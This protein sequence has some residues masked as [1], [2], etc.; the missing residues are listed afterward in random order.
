MGGYVAPLALSGHSRLAKGPKSPVL[1]SSASP[2]KTLGP[3]LGVPE[4]DGNA[5]GYHG[6]DRWL[7]P[8]R[9]EVGW[10]REDIT[11]ECCDRA[12]RRLSSRAIDC[13]VHLCEKGN[14]DGR[15]ANPAN[16]SEEC[17][18]ET[19]RG[20]NVSACHYE[21]AGEPRPCE[22]FSSGASKPTGPQITE[23]VEDAELQASHR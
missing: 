9:W 20:K 14:R 5:S 3:P 22:L 7:C 17:M 16:R 1:R 6:R 15:A 19:E 10:M 21:K 18:L 11:N 8:L 12:D 4:S 13:P 2:L 23:C